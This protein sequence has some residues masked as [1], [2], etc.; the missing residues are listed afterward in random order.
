MLLE[1]SALWEQIS[2]YTWRMYVPMGWIYATTYFSDAGNIVFVPDP[3]HLSIL[4]T[5]TREDD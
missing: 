3:D 5:P 1:D 4:F 2:K